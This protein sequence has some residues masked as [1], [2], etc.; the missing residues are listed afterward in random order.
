M[1]TSRKILDKVSFVY[2][3]I[4]SY[5][6]NRFLKE[7]IFFKRE[8]NLIKS[9]NKGIIHIRIDLKYFQLHDS[10]IIKSSNLTHLNAFQKIDKKIKFS[11]Q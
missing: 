2:H 8:I 6:F 10:I 11:L 1:I 9:L 7:L 5:L 3:R 4:K